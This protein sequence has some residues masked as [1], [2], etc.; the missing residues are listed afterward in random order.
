MTGDKTRKAKYE[1]REA[2]YVRGFT[3][4]ELLLVVALFS[5]ASLGIA[6][7]YVNFMRLERRASNAEQLGEELRYIGELVVRAARNNRVSYVGA[8]LTYKL[9]SLTLV[10]SNNQNIVIEQLAANM[11][12]CYG[13]NVTQGCLTLTVPGSPRT[14]LSGKNID[15][16]QFAVYVN[17]SSDP[18][19]PIG[20]G[21]YASNKQPIVTVF[22]QASYNT[23]NPREKVTINFQ[24]SVDSRIYTR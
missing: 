22:I 12:E 13:L 20:L 21:T 16:N 15:I 9:S 1:M 6:A 10:N 5:V 23:T 3:M 2:R 14:A 4:V 24:T 7:I 18:Y 17:P 19:T 8:P 11:T